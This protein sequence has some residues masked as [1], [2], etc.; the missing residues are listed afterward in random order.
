MRSE[1]VVA[2]ATNAPDPHRLAFLEHF[3]NEHLKKKTSFIPA[4]S[5]VVG[6]DILSE[7]CGVPDNSTAN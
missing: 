3:S 5:T 4:G 1:S 7:R 6:T 2:V